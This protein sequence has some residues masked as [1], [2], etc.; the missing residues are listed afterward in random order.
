MDA[1]NFVVDDGSKGK[2]VKHFRAVA[3]DVD[4]A[5]FAEALVVE[6]VDLG[7]L[8]RLVIASNESDSLWVA[9][10]KG[11]QEEEGLNGVVATIHEVTHEQVVGVGALASYLE[12]L[13]QV[14]E[15]TMDV[16]ANLNA[17]EGQG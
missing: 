16:T 15:L 10:L 13:H 2:V 1:E 4:R 8:A 12:K 7:D 9:H 14:I 11:E 5:I 3:P 6:A 17:K